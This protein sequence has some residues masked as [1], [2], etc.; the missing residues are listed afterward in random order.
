VI[1]L[2]FVRNYSKIFKIDKNI[3]FLGLVSLFTD[4]SS[5]MLAAVIPLFLNNALK[6][7]KSVIGLIEGVAESAASLLKVVS[8]RLSDKTR[9]RKP[10]VLAG[11]GLSTTVKP[12]LLLATGWPAVLLYRFFDRIGKGIRTAPRDAIIADYASVLERGKAFGFHRTMDTIGA[13]LG[14]A[15]A[16]ALMPATPEGS[17]HL[18]SYRNVFLAS[19]VPGIIALLIIV[20]LVKEK[21]RKKGTPGESPAILFSDFSADFKKFLVVSVVLNLAVITDAFLLLR[22]QELGIPARFIPLVLLY[23]NIIQALLSMPAGI[24]SDYIGRKK[25]IIIGYLVFALMSMGFAFACRLYQVLV[26]F[27]MLGF[28]TALTNGVQRAYV[29]DLVSHNVRGTALGTFNAITGI[30]ALPSGL[31][32]GVLWQLYGA[33]TAFVFGALLAISGILMLTVFVRSTDKTKS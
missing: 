1:L 11:Y 33:K 32:T 3:T 27:A 30:T 4:I 8:G 26:L 28:F 25:V 17:L 16:F 15:L 2:S 31:I 10:W 21:E 5:E 6:A 23:Y 29:V 14:P 13:V 7:D 20:F 9:R 24:V 19:L 12:L 18:S 22:A